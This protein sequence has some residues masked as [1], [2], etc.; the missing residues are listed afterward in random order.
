MRKHLRLFAQTLC[1]GGKPRFQGLGL[2]KT[3]TLLHALLLSVAGG[4]SALGVLI[5]DR[6]QSRAMTNKRYPAT[7]SPVCPAG[8][9][10]QKNLIFSM[11]YWLLRRVWRLNSVRLLISKERF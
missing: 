7:V 8:D 3:A 6:Y 9:S 11:S 5:T 4:G 1:F 10:I 2:F